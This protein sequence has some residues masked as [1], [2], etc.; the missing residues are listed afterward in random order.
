MKMISEIYK[1]NFLRLHYIKTSDEKTHKL[2]LPQLTTNNKISDIRNSS[3]QTTSFLQKV[4]SFIIVMYM[5][6]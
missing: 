3:A 4:D 5:G 2:F 1:K 6:Q